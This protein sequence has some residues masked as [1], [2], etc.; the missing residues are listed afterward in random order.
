MQR[1]TWFAVVPGSPRPRV[2]PPGGGGAA[3]SSPAIPGA[4]PP[5]RTLIWATSGASV[6][7]SQTDV[8]NFT[9]VPDEGEDSQLTLPSLK[10]GRPLS[11]SVTST[12]GGGYS[13][14]ASGSGTLSS[15]D[16]F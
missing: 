15:S 12:F 13:G 14:A 10:P 9:W 16:D 8:Y 1:L 4:L 3:L 6:S 5:T 7:G 2:R 11:L